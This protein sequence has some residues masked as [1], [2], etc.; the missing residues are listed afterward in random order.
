MPIDRYTHIQ[1][2][3]KESMHF[4]RAEYSKLRGPA[5]VADFISFRAYVSIY[6]YRILPIIG[7]SQ[8]KGQKANIVPKD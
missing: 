6:Q 1:S 4:C 5:K 2:P 7:G 8:D 3:P